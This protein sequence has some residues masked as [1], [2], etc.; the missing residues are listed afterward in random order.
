MIAAPPGNVAFPDDP[1]DN[2]ALPGPFI[3]MPF[4]KTIIGHHGYP[5]ETRV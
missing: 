3:D 2:R 5:Q 4:V 1:R